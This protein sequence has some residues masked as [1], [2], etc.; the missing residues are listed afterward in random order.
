VANVKRNAAMTREGASVLS[1]ADKDRRGG[2]C[3]YGNE[4]AKARNDSA[5]FHVL[6]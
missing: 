5:F 1:E 4:Q 3:Q 6:L 2:D